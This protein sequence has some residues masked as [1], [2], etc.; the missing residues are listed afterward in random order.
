MV[1]YNRS[2]H[3][4]TLKVHSPDASDAIATIPAGWIK[5]VKTGWIFPTARVRFE[6]EGK[7]SLS[8]LCFDDLS[9]TD[10][11]PVPPGTEDAT[12]P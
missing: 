11:V 7:G 3:V 6:I 4:V 1:V 9:F 12:L 5:R 2:D 8:D 10:S